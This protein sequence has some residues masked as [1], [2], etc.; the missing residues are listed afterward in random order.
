MITVKKIFVKVKAAWPSF[1]WFTANVK[2]R[3]QSD[4][5]LQLVEQ[6]S[7]L[8]SVAFEGR[9]TTICTRSCALSR[10]YIHKSTPISSLKK[11]KWSLQGIIFILSQPIGLDGC[12]NARRLVGWFRVVKKLLMSSGLSVKERLPMLSLLPTP[13][14]QVS[15]RVAS[16]L[17]GGYRE[18]NGL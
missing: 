18:S 13:N 2:N 15:P 6:H 3:H 7:E 16:Q 12:L 10:E 1:R 11:A 4:D 14:Q 17:L 5:S 9:G 8:V